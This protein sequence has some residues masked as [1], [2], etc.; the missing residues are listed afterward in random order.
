MMNDNFYS[1]N[2]ECN[3]LVLSNLRC[4]LRIEFECDKRAVKSK[5]HPAYT[6]AA[7]QK[8]TK[9]GADLWSIRYL[10]ILSFGSYL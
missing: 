4:S 7:M 3:I 10:A 8:S 9:T 5:F 1:W 6:T 2:A